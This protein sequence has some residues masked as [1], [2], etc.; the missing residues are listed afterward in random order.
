M[1]SSTSNQN[2]NSIA[3]FAALKTA[4]VNGE[5]QTI[6]DLICGHPMQELEKS[7]LI[8]LANLNNNSAIIKL[9]Q[10]IPVKE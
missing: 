4:I 2:D 7:Y 10:D 8:D 5:V 3:H 9:L 1:T 6:K